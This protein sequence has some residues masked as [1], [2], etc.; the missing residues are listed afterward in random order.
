VTREP[1]RVLGDIR[2]GFVTADVA[3][4]DYGVILKSDHGALTVDLA[5]THELRKKMRRQ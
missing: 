1:E 2:E 4:R 3:E 5:A